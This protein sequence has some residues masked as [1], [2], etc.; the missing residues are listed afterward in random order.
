MY[1]SMFPIC[2]HGRYLSLKNLQAH[3]CQDMPEC[4]NLMFLR[5]LRISGTI[6]LVEHEPF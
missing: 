6:K 3:H 2:S 5:L 1:L 4:H